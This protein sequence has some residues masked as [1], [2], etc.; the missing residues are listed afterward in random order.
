M[1]GTQ[2]LLWRSSHCLVLLGG[3]HSKF[4]VSPD[5]G[6]GEGLAGRRIVQ[7]LSGKWQRGKVGCRIVSGQLTRR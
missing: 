6:R 3:A 1:Q 5:T 4:A 2:H 7:R